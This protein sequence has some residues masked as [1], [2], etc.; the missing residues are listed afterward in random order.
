M[1]S[2]LVHIV[3]NKGKSP[4][5]VADEIGSQYLAEIDIAQRK[6]LGQFFTPP[7]VAQFMSSFYVSPNT[8]ISEIK[9]LDPGGGTGIL[10]C[11]L[12]ERIVQSHKY[13]KKITLTI[14]EI[15]S[16]LSK[17]TS[18][19]LEYLKLWLQDEYDVQFIYTLY[20]GDFIYAY[21]DTLEN[22]N[23]IDEE[24][25]IIISNPPYFKIQKTDGRVK[26]NDTIVHGQPNIYAMF[27]HTAA[28]LLREGGQ[29]IFIT[30]RSFSS[31][32]YFRLF[33]ERFFS[34]VD[35]ES[36]HLFE[37]R[38]DA[39]KR[40]AVLQEN[41][42]ISAR[43]VTRNKSIHKITIS[44]SQGISDIENKSIELY[45]FDEIFDRTSYQKILHLPSSRDEA[46]VVKLFKSWKG[47]LNAYNIQIST[48]PVVSY[49]ARQYIFAT[50]QPDM[51]LAPLYLLYNASKMKWEWPVSR[52][53]KEQY[54]QV[55]DDTKSLL[56][57]NKNYIFLRRFSSKDDHSRLIATPYFADNVESNV[58]GVENH[59]NYIYRPHGHLDRRE[60]LGLSALLNSSLFD[61]YFR[62]FNGN[63][64]VSATELRE[65]P[66]PDISLIMELGNKLILENNFT[67]NVVDEIVRQFFKSR[68]ELRVA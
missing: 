21:A 50:Q 1:E 30:P 35:L 2:V 11:A 3:D 40:D 26:A 36:V 9:I 34:L 6:G 17:Y 47:N 24:Y 57:P 10:S 39:F 60:I 54:I 33:R 48:G 44:T 61:T 20:T 55:C 7:L 12:I 56:I 41:I 59:L 63:I 31:G 68:E 43:R 37:S 32:L 53:N 18:Q 4:T 66:L 58:I 51:V 19:V 8:K 14:Y 42:I 22:Q 45:S 67:Q 27:L 28:S 64:N 23:R 38:T 16:D 15:D 25:D 62:T 52:N 5:Q 65:M 49:R 29:L 13:P 46:E